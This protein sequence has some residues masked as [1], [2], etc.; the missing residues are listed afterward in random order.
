MVRRVNKQMAALCQGLGCLVPDALLAAAGRC[1]SANEFGIMISG[2]NVFDDEML[3]DLQQH[4]RYEGYEAS[5]DAII[6]FWRVVR[7]RFSSK[8]RAALLTF[9]HGCP[10]I[11]ARGFQHLPGY[12]GAVHQFSIVWVE[13]PTDGS[14]LREAYPRAQT[15]F[16]KLFLPAYGTEAEMETRLCTVIENNTGG[17]DEA[18]AAA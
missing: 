7:H 5:D 3:N 9:V 13:S 6:S 8:Q 11:P 18:A 10:R 15:C 4:T 1:F 12:N 14:E 2:I 17:F 16:N